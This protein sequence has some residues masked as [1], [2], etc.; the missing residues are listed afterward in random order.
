M[1]NFLQTMM[2]LTQGQVALLQ[3]DSLIKFAP[4]EQ[5]QLSLMGAHV[6]RDRSQEKPPDWYDFLGEQDTVYGSAGKDNGDYGSYC[7]GNTW[8][9]KMK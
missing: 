2:N 3:K 4:V 1:R 9:T 5:R 7:L 6:N 8:T